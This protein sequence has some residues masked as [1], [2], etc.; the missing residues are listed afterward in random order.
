MY[1]EIQT[2]LLLEA[3]DVFDLFLDEFFVL[4]LG[5]LALAE[6]STSLADFFS[7]LHMM[8]SFQ[9]KCSISLL[10]GNDPMVVVGNLGRLRCLA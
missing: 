10:T 7:L 6:L 3:N 5:D 2:N 4:R 8:I 1:Q 9:C